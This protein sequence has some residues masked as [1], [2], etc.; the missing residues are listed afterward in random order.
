[1]WAATVHHYVFLE[2][3]SHRGD[4][5]VEGVKRAFAEI[6]AARA[7]V[8][9]L[10]PQRNLRAIVIL[11]SDMDELGP[12]APECI[13]LNPPKGLGPKR[14]FFW[15][16]AQ[17]VDALVVDLATAG[18]FCRGD[19]ELS[20]PTWKPLRNLSEVGRELERPTV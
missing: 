8:L 9:L 11:L 14:F 13:H 5:Y 7:K 2:V 10:E 15:R 4:G 18:F 16:K 17:R 6:L 12:D 19:I 3:S 1:L 20:E